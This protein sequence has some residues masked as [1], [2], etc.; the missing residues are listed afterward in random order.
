MNRA[1][2]LTLSVLLL[3]PSTGM[4]AKRKT[5]KTSATTTEVKVEE[6]GVLKNQDVRV[7]QKNLYAKKGRH[8]FGFLLSTQPWDAYTAGFMLGFNSTLNPSERLGFEL[9]VQGGYGFGN[10]HYRDVTFLGN[11]A[12]GTLTGLGT[13]AVR[14]LVGGGA[15]LVWSPV[16]AK[17]AWGGRKVIHFDVN[18]TLG[19][20]AFLAQ[21][22]EADEGFA[23]VIGPTVG[24]GLKFFLS[25]KTALKIDL[26]DNIALETRAYTGKFTARNNF[27][28]GI[29]LA[30]YLD[31][32]KG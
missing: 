25:P 15:N 5:Q 31:P 4:A 19:F 17:L 21:R 2:L 14:Q 6:I 29:G 27:Q 23:A 16:Y 32:K 3:V 22:L 24:V 7:V 8:E 13:D 20:H 18:L 12:G 1:L 10:G 26:R 9:A 28:F 11:S 30:F